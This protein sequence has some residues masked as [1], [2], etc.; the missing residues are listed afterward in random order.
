MIF[1]C[2]YIHICSYHALNGSSHGSVLACC[3]IFMYNILLWRFLLV[4]WVNANF[5]EKMS[6]WKHGCARHH[7]L[8]LVVSINPSIYNTYKYSK[9]EFNHDKM[10]SPNSKLLLPNVL[11]YFCT[12]AWH[13]V[14]LSFIYDKA[15]DRQNGPLLSHFL[16][17]H[18]QF[19]S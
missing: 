2:I 7:N 9:P 1:C 17:L 3:C 13:L 5:L 18:L 11:E 8:N 4:P 19:V 14:Y 12:S 6:Q 15:W 16:S 10:N